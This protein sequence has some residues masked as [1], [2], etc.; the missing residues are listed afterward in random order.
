MKPKNLFNKI[1]SLSLCR[2]VPSHA[3]V[4]FSKLANACTGIG[5]K[6]KHILIFLL[7][8]LYY[9]ELFEPGQKRHGKDFVKIIMKTFNRHKIDFVEVVMEVFKFMDYPHPIQKIWFA[10][11]GCTTT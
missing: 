3:R 9:P 7:C 1:V 10:P 6:V 11:V 5:D 2:E 4:D 8:H